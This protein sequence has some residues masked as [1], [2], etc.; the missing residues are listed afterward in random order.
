VN[1][2][3]VVAFTGSAQTAQRLRVHPQIVRNS[4]R[5]T[6][7]TDSLNAAILGPDAAPGTPEF[8]LFVA[9]VVKEM[10]FK[11]GQ[12]CTAIRRALVPADHLAA[13]SAALR[14][15]FAGI[16]VGDPRSEG[17]TMGPLASVAHVQDVRTRIDELR[18]EAEM[19]VPDPGSAHLTPAVSSHGAFIAPT[20][21]RVLDVNR[22]DAIHSIEA[23]GPV[24][25][26]LP[27]ETVDDAIALARR[28]GGSLV[29]SAFTAD[30]DIARA[31]M[32]G[33]APYH[34]RVLIVD[35][36]CGK[37]Q[38]GHGSPL[39]GLIHGGPGRAGGGEELGGM[40]AVLHYMQR[41]ALQGSPAMIATVVPP[42]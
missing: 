37:E 34:G 29:A 33:L 4:V 23:F 22:A 41:T 1:C 16:V 21:L 27:Y 24:C 14:T 12:R 9:E 17:T 11:A 32:L 38:T 40:R 18:R 20:L 13:I 19:L 28:G 35:R 8:D 39:P 5:F 26:L 31:L 2:Q 7:E 6:A 15:A 25:T 10:T 30:P 42:G 36:T 3:D